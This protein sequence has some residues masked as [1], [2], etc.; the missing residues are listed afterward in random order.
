[1][2]G[3]VADAA[4]PRSRRSPSCTA[5]SPT[6]APTLARRG[7]RGGRR[8]SSRAAGPSPSRRRDRRHGGGRARARPTCATFWEN[9]LRGR[10]RDHRGPAR[11]LGLAALLRPRPEG[12]RQDHV[13][14]GRV[15]PRRP[16]RPAPLRHA[17]DEPAVD[18]AAAAADARG[19]PRGARRRRLSRPALPPRADGRRPRASAAARRSWRWATP[20]ARTCRCSTRSS[21]AAGSEA[22]ERCRGAAARVDRGLVPRHPAERRGRPGRQP[23]R[24]GRG[25]LHGRRRLRLVAG[26]GGAGGPRAGDRRGRHGDPRRRRHGPEPVHVP[27]LQQD[28]RLLAAGPVPAVRRRRP[29]ASSSARGSPSWCSSGWPTPS[30]TATGSTR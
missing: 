15:P 18:R 3:Q 22:I 25:E 2:L 26:G 5:R 14:V 12:A 20:S 6:A 23:V 17:A 11:P 16:V 27:G 8:R 29:T 4:R 30:A 19:G 24:P 1:M 9:T 7:S 13:E 28:A 21:P 10:R